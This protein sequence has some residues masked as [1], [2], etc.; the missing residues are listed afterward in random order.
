MDL[1]HFVIYI[2]ERLR[3][4][5]LSS[6]LVT[7]TRLHR[8]TSSEI[9]TE[10]CQVIVTTYSCG[11]TAN[12]GLQEC[13]T[14]CCRLLRTM[15]RLQQLLRDSPCP[16]H[17]EGSLK[18]MDAARPAPVS[19]SSQP[20]LPSG[21][22]TLTP[23]R[24]STRGNS[25]GLSGTFGN[26]EDLGRSQSHGASSK[27][28]TLRVEFGGKWWEISQE[29]SR[30]LGSY[31]GIGTEQAKHVFR[32]WIHSG[33]VKLVNS[34]SLL[35]QGPGTSQSSSIGQSSPMLEAKKARED[36]N[37]EKYNTAELMEG[38]RQVEFTRMPMQWQPT[39]EI[40]DPVVPPP[41][42]EEEDLP[43]TR[44]FARTYL[45]RQPRDNS[46]SHDE[47]DDSDD[48]KKQKVLPSGL[49]E[50]VGESSSSDGS[51]KFMRDVNPKPIFRKRSLNAPLGSQPQ[52]TEANETSSVVTDATGTADPGES[53]SRKRR[54]TWMAPLTLM[55]GTSS[56]E[57][58]GGRLLPRNRRGSSQGKGSKFFS[59]RSFEK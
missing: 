27:R 56:R 7:F 23:R 28:K 54:K 44:T 50:S 52:R 25:T 6:S 12:G 19:G 37:R 48:V 46:A 24:Y 14:K 20:L 34:E 47:S 17:S 31:G 3:L 22:G 58:T 49:D 2:S 39:N 29:Q 40:G 42:L 53:S 33:K 36:R 5:Q 8:T 26:L 35:L 41:R 11:C 15:P 4:Q 9:F 30:Q 55:R 21:A 59:F 32:I 13:E 16:T 45:A 18:A 1:R 51:D 38:L 10:M 43:V 57:E